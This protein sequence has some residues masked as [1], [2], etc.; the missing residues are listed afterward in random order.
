MTNKKNLVKKLTSLAV[1]M[2]FCFSLAAPLFANFNGSYISGTADSPARAAI[3]KILKMPVGTETPKVT[4][5]FEFKSLRVDENTAPTATDMPGIPSRSITFGGSNDLEFGKAPSQEPAIAGQKNVYQEVDVFAGVVWP[6][7]GSYKYHVKETVADSIY[8]V[9]TDTEE[10]TYSQAEYEIEVIVF[11]GPNGLYIAYIAASRTVTDDG[12]VTGGEKVDPTPG[13]N[14][15]DYFFSQMIFTNKYAHTNGGP[16]DPPTNPD[17]DKSVLDV[18][19]KVAGDGADATKMFDFTITA[20]K[21]AAGVK[22]DPTYVAYIFEKNENG[23]PVTVGNAISIPVGQDISFSLKHG[24]WLAFMDLHVGT[25]VVVTE[26]AVASYKASY[27]SLFLGGTVADSNNVENQ[28][29]S[30]GSKYIQE[31][32]DGGNFAAFTN[33]IK[34]LTPTTGLSINDLPYFAMIAMALVGMVGYMGLRTRRN[35]NN[36]Q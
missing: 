6:H 35:A 17:P 10:W 7:A 30:T 15:V 5:S 4:Y 12:I 19:K 16:V 32:K 29:L 8:H 18:S 2:V 11:D 27:T 36:I 13:G 22:D 24:Q 23:D 25:S 14:N 34:D 21:P 1:A 9:V 3:T 33:T 31:S 26:K 28:S 20:T